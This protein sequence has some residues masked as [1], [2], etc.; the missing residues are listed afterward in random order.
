VAAEG[1]AGCGKT[2]V[3]CESFAGLHVWQHRSRFPQ[4]AQKVRPARP[5]RVKGRS[6]PFGVR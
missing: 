4:D 1:V 2:I 3:S 6:V 5:Q